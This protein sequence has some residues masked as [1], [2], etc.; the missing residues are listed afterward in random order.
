MHSNEVTSPCVGICQVKDSN[1]G[2]VCVGC[3][4]TVEEIAYWSQ[5]NNQQKQRVLDQI[6]SRELS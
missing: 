3:L 6:K 4:R 2:P 1:I 5:M